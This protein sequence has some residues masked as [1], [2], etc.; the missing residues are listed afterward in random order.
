MTSSSEVSAQVSALEKRLAA[1]EAV[2]SIQNLKARYGDLVDA[3]FSR[4]E[5]VESH[6][7]ASIARAAA[8]LFTEDAVWDGGPELGVAVGRAAIAERLRTP[9]LTFARHFFVRPRI[10]VDLPTASARWELLSPCCTRDGRSWWMFGYEDDDYRL[11]D[12]TWRHA[13]MRLTTV[14]M[15]PLDQASFRVLG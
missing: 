15:S 11:E 14:V 6:A 7:L 5:V 9:T 10:D 12:G 1:A 8:E 3:R 2:L 4:G 13:S